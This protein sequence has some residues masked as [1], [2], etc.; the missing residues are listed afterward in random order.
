MVVMEIYSPLG[1]NAVYFVGH[2]VTDG[3]EEP[4]TSMFMLEEVRC[5]LTS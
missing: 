3:S 4:G 5:D 1:G 2:I